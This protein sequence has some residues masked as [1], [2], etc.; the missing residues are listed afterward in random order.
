[1]CQ[2][3]TDARLPRQLSELVATRTLDDAQPLSDPWGSPYLIVPHHDDFEVITI[4]P[5]QVRGTI[6]DFSSATVMPCPSWT[7]PNRNRGIIIIALLASVAIL[8]AFSIWLVRR[9][10]SRVPRTTID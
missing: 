3:E 4:G 6:D 2:I 8:V 9:K 1:M 7:Q 5:D 10:K